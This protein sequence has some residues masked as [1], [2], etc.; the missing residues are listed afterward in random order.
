MKIVNRKAYHEYNMVQEFDAGIKLVG[1]EVKP[2]RSGEVSFQ[3]AYCLIVNNQVVLR[4]LYIAKNKMAHY[5][6]HDERRER[7]LL[8]NKK[9]IRRIESE[10]KTNNGLTIIP[11]VIFEMNGKFKVKICLAKGKKLWD[12]KETKKNKDVE[13]EIRR[14][15][16]INI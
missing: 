14:T 1:S 15:M 9:E 2:L 5:T 10:V 12:K 3:D 6:N 13:R 7:T 4:N 8:L 11:V 16:N